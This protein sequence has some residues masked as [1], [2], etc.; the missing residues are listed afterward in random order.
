MY[1]CVVNTTSV[2]K[3]NTRHFNCGYMS[4]EDRFFFFTPQQLTIFM[5]SKYSRAK[6]C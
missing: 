4:V 3:R 2:I 6:I 1:F 5:Q